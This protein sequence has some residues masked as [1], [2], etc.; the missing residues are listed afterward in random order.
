MTVEEYFSVYSKRNDFERFMSFYAENAAFEDIVYGNTFKNKAQITEFL[1]W[2][3]G[4][5]ELPS[6][7]KTLTVTKQVVHN[8]IAVTEGYFHQFSYNDQKLGPWLFVIIQEFDENKK[9]IR[10]TDWINYTPRKKFLGGKN[11]NDTISEL[12]L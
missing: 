2:N 11:M 1:N 3:N 7:T 5:F 12:S 4:K 10:Q 9:I 6:G 8:N